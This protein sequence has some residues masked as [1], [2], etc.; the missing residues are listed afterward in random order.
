MAALDHPSSRVQALLC[1]AALVFATVLCHPIAETGIYDDWS[2]V[3]TAQSLAQTGRIHYNGW[4]TAMLGWQLYPAAACFRLFGYSFTVARM[5]TIAVAAITAYMCHRCYT[6]LGCRPF[7][8]SLATLTLVL[9]PLFLPLATTFM[10]DVFGL[11]A[12]VACLYCC[13]RALEA[14]TSQSVLWLVA[15]AAVNVV[16]GTAR[17]IA[18]LGVLVM[19]PST[20]WLLRH[21]RRVV[22]AGA[23]CWVTGAILI[24]AG[25]RWFAHQPY[26]VP[27]IFPHA[28]LSGS[29]VAAGCLNL[30]RLLLELGL[31]TLPVLAAF[32]PSLAGS[33]RSLAFSV[34][35]GCV[36]GAGAV[37]AH[38]YVH[39][40]GQFLVPTLLDG[41][42]YV[43]PEGALTA[44][45][46]HGTRPTL[47]PDAVRLFLTV[48]V[49]VACLAV[50]TAAVRYRRDP[51]STEVHSEVSWSEVIVLTAPL[52]LAY[53]LLLMPRAAFF[54]PYDR[55]SL[56]LIAVGLV[57]LMRLYQQVFG[58]RRPAVAVV[59]VVIF[60]AYSIATTHDAFAMY[61]GTHQAVQQMLR[62][63]VQ[64]DAIDAGWESSGWT[65]IDEGGF[66]HDLRLNLKEDQGHVPEVDSRP[67]PFELHYLF[68][69]V[70][71]SYALAFQP[72]LCGGQAPFPVIAFRTWL[73]W[74]TQRIYVVHDAPRR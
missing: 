22:V 7:L 36:L 13:V 56:P 72:D 21:D 17:Q 15:A 42:N 71:P 33:R 68:P 1:A 58:T 60:G 10:S 26:A 64:A 69:V 41:G 20:A 6:R 49:V 31:L 43:G 23:L 16:G 19:V 74:S 35:L 24:F 63:G 55:Y 46:E 62:Q 39:H 53:L 73:P 66:V 12:I 51:S 67:C 4:A 45:P 2:Y 9:S 40:M 47:L 37:I 70:K 25:M 61:N 54:H 34:M 44:W 11:L 14:E 48:V 65:Q 28:R 57:P 5:T 27:E 59:L 29:V 52:S 30:L 3:R 50:V 32:L 38:H 8:A 18:W